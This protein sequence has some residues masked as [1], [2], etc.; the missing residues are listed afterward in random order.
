MGLI[1]KK[2][3]QGRWMDDNGGDWSSY[4]TGTNAAFTGRVPGWDMP[5]HDLAIIN[6]TN[7][8]ISYAR[9]LMNICMAVAVN[10]ATGKISVVG[11]D[12]LNNLR[13][14]DDLESIFIR[15]KLA[16]VDPLT[17]NN[18][19]TDLNPHLNYLD[20]MVAQTERD[21]SIGD[22]RG[23][24]WSSDGARAYVT[25]MGSDN[26]III[27]AAG[28]RAGLR[29]RSTWGRGRQGWRWTRAQPSVCIQP[30]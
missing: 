10:P 26:L 30:F 5:D 6:T 22:P 12:A 20:Q 7:F 13:F 15:V 16:Q 18:V 3:G 27:D 23:I 19:V 17:L 21:K 1:V 24:V 4:I 11:T 8:G 2:D 28:N 14:Q 29:Q 25:G 9:G